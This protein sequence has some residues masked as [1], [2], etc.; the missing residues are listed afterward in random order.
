MPDGLS[1][2]STRPIPGDGN[3][4]GLPSVSSLFSLESG[5]W[6]QWQ[7]LTSTYL[8][9]GPGGPHPIPFSQGVNAPNPSSYSHLSLECGQSSVWEEPP[10]NNARA[11]SAEA[12]PHELE[13]QFQVHHLFLE[14]PHWPSHHRPSPPDW[15]SC[16]HSC[17]PC[18]IPAQKPKWSFK[19]VN[20]MTK[21]PAEIHTGFPLQSE[22]I[23][24]HG[25]QA[26]FRPERCLSLDSSPSPSSWLRS[27]HTH[28]SMLILT[29][30]HPD[31]LSPQSRRL[32]HG[33]LQWLAPPRRLSLCLKVILWPLDATLSFSP[34]LTVNA[35]WSYAS[36][37]WN[38]LKLP[39]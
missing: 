19:Q 13:H 12:E 6:L 20:R 29:S 1:W 30:G 31:L 27:P 18:T 4:Q 36:I 22:S 11:L 26:P 28:W 14:K 17:L 39:T 25:W 5:V 8:E 2:R 7:R 33:P 35:I 23:P 10:G 34:T 37:Y 15:A 9:H 32:F 16:V 38:I 3:P 21:S 24:R